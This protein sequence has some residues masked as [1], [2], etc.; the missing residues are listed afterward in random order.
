MPLVFKRIIF[1]ILFLSNVVNCWA[2]PDT[3]IVDYDNFSELITN[4]VEYK[5]VD[6]QW[7]EGGVYSD[8]G[9]SKSD[10]KAL[11]FGIT[12]Q[13]VWVRFNVKSDVH[14][15]YIR[16]QNEFIDVVE[17]YDKSNISLKIQDYV[18]LR[19]LNFKSAKPNTLNFRV[20]SIK[21]CEKIYLFVKS[22]MGLILPLN[23]YDYQA[24]TQN[25]ERRTL[26]FGL[27]SGVFLVV[28]FYNLLIFSII[29]D[30]AYLFYCFLSASTYFTQVLT[31]GLGNNSFYKIMSFD[32]GG[33]I[34]VLVGFV[35]IFSGFFLKKYFAKSIISHEFKLPSYIVWTIILSG[36][37]VI[38]SWLT[39][40]RIYAFIFMN[41]LMIYTAFAC[42]AVILYLFRKNILEAKILLLAWTVF[43]LGCLIFMASNFGIIP[44]SNITQYTMPIGASLETILLSLALGFRINE[45]QEEKK[46]GEMLVKE[47]ANNVQ[48]AELNVVRAEMRALRSQMNP[49]FIFNGLNTINTSIE[50]GETS[51]AGKMLIVF[52]KLIRKTLE[53]SRV[54]SVPISSELEY[55]NAYL[56][57]EGEKHHKSFEFE[58]NVDKELLETDVRI[59]PAMIQTICENSIKHAFNKPRKIRN[60]IS[61]SFQKSG[62]DKSIIVVIRDN[63]IGFSSYDKLFELRSHGIS[64]LHERLALMHDQKEEAAISVRWVKPKEVFKG[65]EVTLILPIRWE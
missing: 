60:L 7:E 31:S 37:L 32:S 45:L 64:M 24:S 47:Y 29:K 9:W 11:N 36:F 23:L 6:S 52:A 49:H 65:T 63:G 61:L 34:F 56:S 20:N 2:T 48:K 16:I 5:L 51:R 28:F 55:L 8:S 53:H 59:P 33:I 13:G 46:I 18:G 26:F 10:R 1:I 39:L 62:S 44:Y 21:E 4:K 30:F 35:A 57:L 27:I 42:F 54:D 58:F 19:Y 15:L 40:D 22:D 12:K 50:L 41:A 38:L 25:S 14:E 3:I 17:L 43:L